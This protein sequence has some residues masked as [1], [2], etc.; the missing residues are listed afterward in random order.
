[1]NKSVSFQPGYVIKDDEYIFF[2]ELFPVE[3][4][5]L[6]N[7]P[8]DDKLPLEVESAFIIKRAVQAKLELIKGCCYALISFI[9]LVRFNTANE[10]LHLETFRGLVSFSDKE[11]RK[12]F[13]ANQQLEFFFKQLIFGLTPNVAQFWIN[14]L[15]SSLLI[16]SDKLSKLHT[17]YVQPLVIWEML[18]EKNSFPTYAEFQ[19][20]EQEFLSKDNT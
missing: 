6:R 12:V 17:T 9:D 11:L 18:S 13:A 20:L 8:S 10:T 15:Y 2:F 7:I 5:Y 16:Q 14:Q 4:S 1:M 3:C 19:A